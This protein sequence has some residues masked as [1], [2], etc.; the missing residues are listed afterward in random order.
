MEPARC[1]WNVRLLIRYKL[2]GSIMGTSR[3]QV[4]MGTEFLSGSENTVNLDLGDVCIHC[5]YTKTT[6]LY[7]SHG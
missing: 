6:D 2:R 1:S 7:A 4:L 5:E 3:L